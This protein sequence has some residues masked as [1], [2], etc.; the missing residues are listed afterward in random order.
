[1]LNFLRVLSLNQF[2]NSHV[3]VGFLFDKAYRNTPQLES[4]FSNASD[5]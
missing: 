2:K 5:W 3:S 4:F 1:M